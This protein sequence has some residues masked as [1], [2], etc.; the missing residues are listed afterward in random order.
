MEARIAVIGPQAFDRPEFNLARHEWEI[1][2]AGLAWARG[3]PCGRAEGPGLAIRDVRETK[4]PRGYPPGANLRW[5]VGTSRGAAL[6]N[7]FLTLNQHLPAK[8]GEGGFLEW[9]PR[10]LDSSG[11]IPWI[12]SGIHLSL[13]A[14]CASP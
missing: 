7:R 11:W 13:S 6:S 2:R 12:P 14:G 1:H 3:M 8:Q 9:L 5:F 10:S 4:R